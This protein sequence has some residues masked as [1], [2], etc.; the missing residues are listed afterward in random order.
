MSDSTCIDE[1]SS[2]DTAS[3]P[4]PAKRLRKVSYL[5][6]VANMYPICTYNLFFWYLWDQFLIFSPFPPLLFL[7]YLQQRKSPSPFVLAAHIGLN[8]I[9]EKEEPLV[10][11]VRDGSKRKRKTT[12]FSTF[13]QYRLSGPQLRPR[14]KNTNAWIKCHWFLSASLL[15][16]SINHYSFH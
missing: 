5:V 13:N 1:I 4:E 9:E 2:S 7:P 16:Y 8:R 15:L 11:D 3:A 12:K 6:A 10:G 14:K